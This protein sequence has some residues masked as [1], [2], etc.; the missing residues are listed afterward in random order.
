MLVLRKNNI[1][2]AFEKVM[3]LLMILLVFLSNTLAVFCPELNILML[4]ES[5]NQYLRKNW[6]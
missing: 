2:D 3:I 4:G 5:G 6:V 1:Y